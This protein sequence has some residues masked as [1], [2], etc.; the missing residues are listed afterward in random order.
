LPRK[1][2]IGTVERSYVHHDDSVDDDGRR[3]HFGRDL[4]VPALVAGCGVER[5]HGAFE[6]PDH[7]QFAVGAGAAGPA[8]RI[9]AVVPD[10]SVPFAEMLAPQRLA[11]CRIQCG[12]GA[13]GARRVQLAVHDRRRHA[14]AGLIRAFADALFPELLHLHRGDDLDERRRRL[15]VFF[16]DVV[17]NILDR[18]AASGGERQQH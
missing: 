5:L 18:L 14:H 15:D 7:Q 6:R 10:E 1:V 16:L 9:V 2:R 12:D 17:E 3:D 8:H 13:V 4:R 11:G